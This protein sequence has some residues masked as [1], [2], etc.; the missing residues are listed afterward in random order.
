M[1]LLLIS[2]LMYYLQGK[3]D[4]YS[5]MR[6]YVILTNMATLAWF[7]ALQYYRFKDTGRACS[8]DFLIKYP[9][10]YREVYLGDWGQWILIYIVSQYV[11]FMV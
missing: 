7:I 6:P 11:V 1:T 9:A 10:N 8:G 3:E 2:A 5:M 4:M